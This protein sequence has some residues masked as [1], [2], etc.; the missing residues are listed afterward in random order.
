MNPHTAVGQAEEEICCGATKLALETRVIWR[1]ELKASKRLRNKGNMAEWSKAL[2]LG[3][4][5]YPVFRGEGSN[6]SVVRLFLA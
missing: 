4:T 6:P 2:E 5:L 1:A 3:F